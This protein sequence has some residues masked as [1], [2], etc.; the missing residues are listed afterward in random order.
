MIRHILRELFTLL[1]AVITAIA[2]GFFPGHVMLFLIDVVHAK[3]QSKWSKLQ[4]K[5]NRVQTEKERG[6]SIV[7]K[8]DGIE[9]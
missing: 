6:I 4:V 2:I 8:L 3:E 7:D 1:A 9:R 5:V